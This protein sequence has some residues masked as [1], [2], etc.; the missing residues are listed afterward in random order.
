MQFNLRYEH[1]FPIL[2][3]LSVTPFAGVQYTY[4]TT[5]GYTSK[6]GRKNAWHTERAD[7]HVFSIPVGLR[8]SGLLENKGTQF[9]PVFSAYVQPNF[10]DTEVENVVRGEG[11]ASVDTVRP[12]VIGE[13]SYGATLG[14][15]IDLSERFTFGVDY[16]FHGS[17]QSRNNALKASMQ[18]AF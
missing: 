6:L 13:W 18:Y 1:S 8:F 11:L 5:E 12:E 10:G 7:Q 4:L 15:A 17:N 2:P 3:Q 16:S 9:H 14:L